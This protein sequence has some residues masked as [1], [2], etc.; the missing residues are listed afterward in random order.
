MVIQLSDYARCDEC[1]SIAK[2]KQVGGA[3][4]LT[5]RCGM[6]TFYYHDIDY[7]LMT[8]E[9]DTFSVD[10]WR[11]VAIDNMIGF[12]PSRWMYLRMAWDNLKAFIRGK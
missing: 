6:T 11:E 8:D 9:P 3:E 7:R 12:T 2:V 5:C 1:G 10:G 4:V